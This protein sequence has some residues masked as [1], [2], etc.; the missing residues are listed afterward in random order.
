MAKG[1]MREQMPT[2]AAFIDDLRTTFGTDYINNILRA[3]ING[4]PVFYAS[5]NGH[6]VGTV[7]PVGVRVGTNARGNRCLLD[8]PVDDAPACRRLHKAAP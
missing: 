5:E 1:D 6:T 2:V 4:K 3:G 7:V 8:G